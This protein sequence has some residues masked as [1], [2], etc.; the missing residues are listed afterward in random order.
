MPVLRI[1][2]PSANRMLYLGHEEKEDSVKE[3]CHD[4][5]LR[6][7]VPGLAWRLEQRGARPIGAG[8]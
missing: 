4:G 2:T 8:H 5:R 7:H 6:L 1:E 3:R